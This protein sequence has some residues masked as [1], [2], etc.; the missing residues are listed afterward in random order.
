MTGKKRKKNRNGWGIE[1]IQFIEDEISALAEAYDYNMDDEVKR[2]VSQRNNTREPT[3]AFN[4][5]HWMENVLPINHQFSNCQMPGCDCNVSSMKCTAETAV[6]YK[7]AHCSE[8]K[9]SVLQ[10]QVRGV[11]KTVGS[12]FDWIKFTR[13]AGS[14]VQ[15]MPW[16]LSGIAMLENM[17]SV[18]K[19]DVKQLK[20][21]V[22]SSRRNEMP[23]KVAIYCDKLYFQLYYTMSINGGGDLLSPD[24]YFACMEQNLVLNER[25]PKGFM[26]EFTEKELGGKVDAFHGSN[27]LLNIH[28]YRALEGLYLFYAKEIGM[29]GE[30]DKVLGNLPVMTKD[31]EGDALPIMPCYPL[32]QQYRD[33]CRDWCCHLY[34]YATP[35]DDA[36]TML[37]EY[38]PLVEIGAGTGF[39]ASLLLERGIA[40]TSYDK[41][42]PQD[43]KCKKLNEFHANANTFSLIKTGGPD[44]LSSQ[45]EHHNLFL[46]YPP[47]ND[48]MARNCLKYFKGKF[49]I[50]VGEYAGDTADRSFESELHK[51]Y[52]LV[53]RIDLPNWCN[54]AYAMTI[55]QRKEKP[56]T[57]SIR[58]QYMTCHACK[59]LPKATLY[60]CRICKTKSYCSSACATSD[61]QQHKSEHAKRLVFLTKL[62]SEIKNVRHKIYT[63]LPT[64]LE[65]NSSEFKVAE[66]WTTIAS[67]ADTFSFNFE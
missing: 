27:S 64:S 41:A 35:N 20:D 48:P 57:D 44:T 43:K 67:K 23:I 39:W 38:Q 2:S 56:D 32:L 29:R 42:P 33:A 14:I 1:Q 63:P 13:I 51:G 8:C 7:K 53:K 36:L 19:E 26:K 16:V 28:R 30:M 47:P 49:I 11:E 9:H 10:H 24:A 54:T 17:E 59:K 60:R 58:L 61:Y 5:R 46:C 25:D 6:L 22:N 18:A 12:A 45:S 55:W 50:H 37:K 31:K 52:Q 66:S 62:S 3:K 34:A 40:I 21:A 15:S 65:F 4:I